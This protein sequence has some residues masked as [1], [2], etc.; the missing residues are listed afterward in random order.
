MKKLL[1]AVALFTFGSATFAQEQSSKTPATATHVQPNPKTEKVE[2]TEAKDVH[3]EIKQDKRTTRHATE[4]KE[5]HDAK[6][7]LR[8]EESKK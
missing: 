7:E 3:T 4:K 2:K 1:I 6:K 5:H 8:K